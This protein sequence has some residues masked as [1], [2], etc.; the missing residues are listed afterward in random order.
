MRNL[1]LAT[2]TLLAAAAVPAAPAEAQSSSASAFVGVPSN[3]GAGVRVHHGFGGHGDRDGRHHRDG[4]FD[5]G[6]AI[7]SWYEGGEWALYNNRSWEADSYNDWWHDRPD[8]AFPRWVQNN[9]NCE[10]VWWSGGGW[11]C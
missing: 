9:Q 3:G 2:A 5:D 8:R 10:R 1:L 6:A 4:R 7:G 11:R